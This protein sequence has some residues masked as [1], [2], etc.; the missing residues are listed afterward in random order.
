M[1][2]R[3]IILPLK[4]K[5]LGKTD[6]HLRYR[7]LS[8]GKPRLVVRKTLRYVTVQFVVYSPE[9]DRVA[10]AAHSRELKNYGLQKIER[11]TLTAYLVG[12]LTGKRARE[13]GLKEAV[14]DIG[15][16]RKTAGSILFAALRGAIDAG[17]TIPHSPKALPPEERIKGK[18]LKGI[19]PFDAILQ[20]IRQE[21][22]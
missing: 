5:R 15:L 19:V 13:K 11:N 16:Y 9:G 20:A 6:Y 7:L 14:L 3:K 21:P 12:Y 10:A 4:R 8:S 17:I 1:K 2:R 18:H 22:A